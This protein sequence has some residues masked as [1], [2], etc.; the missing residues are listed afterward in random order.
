MPTFA[1]YQASRRVWLPLVLVTASAGIVG[2]AGSGEQASATGEPTAEAEVCTPIDEAQVDA[3]FERWNASLATGDPDAVVANYAENG[4][5]QPTL[6]AEMRTTPEEMRDY[7]VGF[8]AR[9]PQ[10]TI[11]EREI[12]LGC[13]VAVDTGNYTF[14]FGDGSSAQARYSF[15]YADEGGQWVI[16]SHHSSL[17]PE[18][19]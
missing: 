12:F 19:E 16:V 14:T 2:C 1:T 13:N 4:V 7:F 3:L 15:V 18:G 11:T 9:Q 5:L 6:S 10:G 8:V 17:A